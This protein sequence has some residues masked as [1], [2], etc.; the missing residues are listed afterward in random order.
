MLTHFNNK[1]SAYSLWPSADENRPN[2]TQFYLSCLCVLC[3]KKRQKKAPFWTILAYF[4]HILA[5]FGVILDNFG[6][7]WDYFGNKKTPKTVFSIL[8]MSFIQTQ[9]VTCFFLPES[10]NHWPESSINKHLK[11]QKTRK[12]KNH[13]KCS[14]QPIRRSNR[15][16]Q[17][18]A[19]GRHQRSV[20]A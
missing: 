9:F 13:G 6:I 8:K 15:R 19:R 11:S 10:Y 16:H 5:H 7:V 4:W 1:T 20:Q 3:G 17:C 18:L 14:C 12:V 2:Q